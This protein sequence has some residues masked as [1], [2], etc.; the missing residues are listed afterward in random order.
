MFLKHVVATIKSHISNQVN[1]GSTT[2]VQKFG[3]SQM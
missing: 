3:V 1:A 2:T